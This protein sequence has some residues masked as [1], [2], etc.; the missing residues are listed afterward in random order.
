MIWRRYN[1]WGKGKKYARK[2][3]KS[4]VA[5]VDEGENDVRKLR[6]EKGKSK[7]SKFFE[8]VNRLLF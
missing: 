6:V 3:I 7:K 5:A 2:M 8:K 1:L 4:Q